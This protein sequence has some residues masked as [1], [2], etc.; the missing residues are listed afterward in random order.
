MSNIESAIQVAEGHCDLSVGHELC[1]III[2]LIQLVILNLFLL[3]VQ[4]NS[5][6][7]LDSE[8]QTGNVF[9]QIHSMFAV[10]IMVK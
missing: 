7:F 3:V 4:T 9:T 2:E 1:N 8:S 5:S 6:R 10:V